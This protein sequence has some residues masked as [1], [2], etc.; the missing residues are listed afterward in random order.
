MTLTACRYDRLIR[1]WIH[2][3][4]SYNNNGNIYTH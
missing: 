2:K 4:G 3:Q 1:D